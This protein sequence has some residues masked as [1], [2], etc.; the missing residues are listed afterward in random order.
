MKVYDL[1][2]RLD[3][4]LNLPLLVCDYES[5]MAYRYFLFVMRS[6]TH[7]VELPLDMRE[8]VCCL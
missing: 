7:F 3:I 8:Q 4:L 2:L 5:D 1:N 6:T